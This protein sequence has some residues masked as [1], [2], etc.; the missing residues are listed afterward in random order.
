MTAAPDIPAHMSAAYAALPHVLHQVRERAFA[1]A[2]NCGVGPLTEA[3]KW[4]QPSFLTEKT[5]AGTTVRL[6]LVKSR[7]AVFFTCHTNLVEGFR[8]D[9]P[10]AFDYEGNRALLLGKDWQQ[11]ALDHCL[12]RALTYHRTKRAAKA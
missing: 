9:L 8:E 12:A 6:G 11:S 10:E 1:V 7:P 2:D 4:G 3:L 5:K